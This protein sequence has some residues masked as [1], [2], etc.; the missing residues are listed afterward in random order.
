MKA[1][2]LRFF[3]SLIAEKFIGNVIAFNNLSEKAI[4][5]K[6]VSLVNCM[7]ELHKNEDRP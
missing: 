1:G 4:H 5:D 2:L 7:I 3:E 6:L